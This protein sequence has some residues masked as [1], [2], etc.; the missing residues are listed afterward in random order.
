MAPPTPTPAAA[1]SSAAATAKRR[2]RPRSRWALVRRV[3][4]I[5]FVSLV[6]VLIFRKMST[7]DWSAVLTAVQ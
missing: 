1:P 3:L 4:G 2:Q 7:I 5:L 6:V